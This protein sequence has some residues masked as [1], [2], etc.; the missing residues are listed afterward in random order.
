[1]PSPLRSRF[2]LGGLSQDVVVGEGR[3]VTC[4]RNFWVATVPSLGP[5][6][7]LMPGLRVE[8]W[9]S[10]CASGEESQE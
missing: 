10:D 1:M 8:A 6:V 7:C 9:S 4:V 3:V 5:D 2:A